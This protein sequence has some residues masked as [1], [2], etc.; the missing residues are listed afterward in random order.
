MSGSAAAGVLAP[1]LMRKLLTFRTFYT[2]LYCKKKKKIMA[3]CW[4]IFV[5]SPISGVRDTRRHKVGEKVYVHRFAHSHSGRRSP[6]G[7]RARASHE[8]SG[9][10][11]LKEAAVDRE[12]EPE[13]RRD[14][15]REPLAPFAARGRLGSRF[16]GPCGCVSTS[17]GAAPRTSIHGA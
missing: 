14:S 8:H 5:P 1:T 7:E 12:P 13:P 4:Q 17:H 10:V 2:F 9:A 11:E 3:L 6:G 15:G 16:R